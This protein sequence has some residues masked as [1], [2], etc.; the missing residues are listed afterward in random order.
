MSMKQIFEILTFSDFNWAEI[1]LKSRSLYI[2]IGSY[3]I[4]K[5]SYNFTVTKLP[6]LKKDLIISTKTP[7][8]HFQ[9]L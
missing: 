2:I 8:P 6:P 3:E 4:D 1:A 5:Y 7:I 9:S